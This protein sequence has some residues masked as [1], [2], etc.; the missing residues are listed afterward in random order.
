[1]DNINRKT[2]FIFKEKWLFPNLNGILPFIFQIFRRW[3]TGTGNA[4]FQKKDI[5][6]ALGSGVVGILVVIILP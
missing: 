6:Q 3:V 4:R 5:W 2:S 1:L